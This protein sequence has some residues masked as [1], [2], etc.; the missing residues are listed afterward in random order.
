[1]KLNTGSFYLTLVT[2]SFSSILSAQN[3]QN[4]TSFIT[5]SVNHAID[6][7]HQVIQKSA[8]LYNGS[9]YEE[10][11]YN[12]QEGSPYFKTK[13]S[14]SGSI[15]YDGVLYENIWMKYNELKDI[16]VIWYNN[17]AVQLSNEKISRFTI[18]GHSFIWSQK[19]NMMKKN[20]NTGFY[21]ELYAGKTMALKKT[22]K[23][24][25]Q[26]TDVSEGVSRFI[27]QKTY[28]YLKTTDGFVQVNNKS[29]LTDALKNH[30]TEIKD[31]ISSKNLNFKQD[32][33]GFIAQ[34]AAYYDTL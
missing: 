30:K 2:L 21:E 6:I 31:F 14:V 26:K 7:Y 29:D 8:G 25:Q 10:Y 27:D 28:F 34:V 18:D 20:I 12:F 9:E 13:D 23:S 15:V 17:D 3:K 1:M 5:S 4:D 19:N 22:I 16:V 11:T 32:T 24:I 33:E